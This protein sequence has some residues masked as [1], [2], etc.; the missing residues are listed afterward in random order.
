MPLSS[1][2]YFLQTQFGVALFQFQAR[3]RPL[4]RVIRLSAVGTLGLLRTTSGEVAQVLTGFLPAEFQ[5]RRRT[6]EFYLRQLSYGRDLLSM[7]P[8]Y[9]GCTHAITPF[10]ML[11]AE[12][13]HLE[14]Y[15]DLPRQLLQCVESRQFWSIAPIDITLPPIPSILPSAL[16][17]Q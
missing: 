2:S 13:A 8:H 10:N 16:A 9:P 14:H 1:P 15:E 6:V 4:D 12:V 5:I 3:V 17:V 11:V 7:D